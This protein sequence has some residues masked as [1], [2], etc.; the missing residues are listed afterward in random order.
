MMDL[1]HEQTTTHLETQIQC[2]CVGRGH[3]SATQWLVHAVVGDLGHGRIK[4]Q[5]QVDTGNKEHHKAVEGD[6]P[7]QE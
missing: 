1:T 4:E 7:Q 3:L 2:A 6:L 5:R